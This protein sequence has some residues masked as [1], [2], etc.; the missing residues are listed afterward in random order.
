VKLY[1]W[2]GLLRGE[3]SLADEGG[4]WTVAAWLKD[5]I[6]LMERLWRRCSWFATIQFFD[7]AVHVVPGPH[8]A[9]IGQVPAQVPALP[10]ISSA[11]AQRL[12]SGEEGGQEHVLR[13][14]APMPPSVRSPY[15]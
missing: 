6:A 2:N 4:A 5:G 12:Y 1:A 15:R 11:E 7:N 8:A 3:Q 9:A 13:L 14:A 10:A